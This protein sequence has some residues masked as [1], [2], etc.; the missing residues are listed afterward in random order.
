LPAPSDLVLRRRDSRER[1][2]IAD[3][4]IILTEEF[5]AAG[6]LVSRAKEEDFEADGIIDARSVTSFE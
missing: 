1:D 4:R 5:N 3:Y 6:M 2:G